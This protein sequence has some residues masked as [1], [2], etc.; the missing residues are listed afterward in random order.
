MNWIVD[1]WHW[2]LAPWRTLS[3]QQAAITRLELQVVDLH[4][5]LAQLHPPQ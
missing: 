2:F 3:D 1:R 5:R 4:T